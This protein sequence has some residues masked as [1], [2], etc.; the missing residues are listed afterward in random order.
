MA[1]A[2]V[3]IGPSILGLNALLIDFV[4]CNVE[5]ENADFADCFQMR[6][7]WSRYTGLFEDESGFLTT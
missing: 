6:Y 1:R 2:S 3:R 7:W 4:D 5:K